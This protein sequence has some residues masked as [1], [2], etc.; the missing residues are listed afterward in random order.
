MSSSK[1]TSK[2]QTTIP[3]EI[4]EKLN[5]KSGDTIV[6]KVVDDKTIVIKKAKSFDKEYLKAIQNTLGEWDSNEDDKAFKHL[7][8]I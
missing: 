3:K 8:D 7:Q 5:L 2:F 1:L 4:R 6:F